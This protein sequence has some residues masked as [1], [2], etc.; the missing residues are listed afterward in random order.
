MYRQVHSLKIAIWN[1]RGLVS[2]RNYKD[3]HFIQ[4]LQENDIFMLC[5]TWTNDNSV[6]NI[7]GYEYVALYRKRHPISSKGL[8][9]Y[10]H[11]LQREH[12]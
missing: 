10:C 7:S 11:I 6:M 2:K 3:P 1:V 5:E 9:C 12:G 8:W 4:R